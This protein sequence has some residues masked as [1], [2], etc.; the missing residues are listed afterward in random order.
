[1]SEFKDAVDKALDLL[2]DGQTRILHLLMLSFMTPVVVGTNKGRETFLQGATAE[3]IDDTS[4]MFPELRHYVEKYGR[5]EGY[6]RWARSQPRKVNRLLYQLAIAY[7]VALFEAFTE[8]LL[9]AIFLHEPRCLA[10]NR[11]VSWETVV[12]LGN[13]ES[14][15]MHMAST[16]I[17]DVVRGD[18][19]AVV[20]EFAD[21][22]KIDLSKT[23]AEEI[24][25]IMEI[26]HAVVHSTGIVDNK[27]LKK[28]GTSRYGISYQLGQEI[29]L[30]INT[31]YR[32]DSGIGDVAY[33]MCEEVLRKFDAK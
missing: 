17:S 25:E 13:H 15:I 21:R 18:W 28:V 22:F 14:L 5:R 4:D 8:D 7:E 6:W 32:I 20:K 11:T 12:S 31:V 23:H 26:R 3:E 27:F 1:M 10:S 24:S 33:M 30:D 29:A 2:R 19:N 16:L 9:E